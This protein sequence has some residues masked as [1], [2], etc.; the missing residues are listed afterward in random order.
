MVVNTNDDR[1][2]SQTCLKI[3][4]FFVPLPTR[5]AKRPKHHIAEGHNSHE[6]R[7]SPERAQA[8][9]CGKYNNNLANN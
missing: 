1:Y 5:S 8:I 2:F 7:A 9:T 6:L 4:F 3:Q